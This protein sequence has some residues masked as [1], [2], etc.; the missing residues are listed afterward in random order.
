[1]LSS[2]RPTPQRSRKS[3]RTTERK[4]RFCD[5]PSIL[6]IAHRTST[7]SI[8][9]WVSWRRPGA[10]GTPSAY[11]GR[12]VPFESPIR[13]EEHGSNSSPT[14]PRILYARSNSAPS[15]RAKCGSLMASVCDRYFPLPRRERRGTVLRI[16]HFRQFMHRTPVSRWRGRTHCSSKRASRVR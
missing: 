1:M 11:S 8:T 10:T 6:A 15:I 9:Q 3:A 7:G 13:F 5:R 14:K 2:C 12:R 4:F 16:S